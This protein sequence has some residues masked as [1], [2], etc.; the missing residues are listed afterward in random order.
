MP[1]YSPFSGGPAAT[2]LSGIFAQWDTGAVARGLASASEKVGNAITERYMQT[3]KDKTSAGHLDALLGSEIADHVLGVTGQTKD[4]VKTLNDSQKA[5]LLGQYISTSTLLKAKDEHD[6]RE[7]DKQIK[8]RT[9]NSSKMLPSGMSSLLGAKDVDELS[10]NFSTFLNSGGDDK[11]SGMTSADLSQL[12]KVY[13][14]QLSGFHRSEAPKEVF[15]GEFVMK[16]NSLYPN[17]ARNRNSFTSTLG[18]LFNDQTVLH[19]QRKEIEDNPGA[20]PSLVDADKALANIDKNIAST[21]LAIKK[22]STPT[23][24]MSFEFEDGKWRID[25]GGG[26]SDATIGTKSEMQKKVALLRATSKQLQHA[27]SLYKDEYVGMSGYFGQKVGDE[28]MGSLPFGWG[29]KATDPG[30]IEFR[31]SMNEFNISVEKTLSAESRFSDKDRAYIRTALANLGATTSPA[32]SRSRMVSLGKLLAMRAVALTEE[33]GGDLSKLG[34]VP[35]STALELFKGGRLEREKL[36]TILESKYKG[37]SAVVDADP[38]E[39]DEIMKRY[40]NKIPD[41]ELIEL[42][43]ELFPKGD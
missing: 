29:E 41:I 3:K 19:K 24:P 43:E 38:S 18:K 28:F 2:D 9:V 42:L 30:R 10:N 20:Y 16:G 39:A 11:F 21:E 33:G 34:W 12:E 40:S 15:N 23:K 27:R 4:S 6:S 32:Q 35:S 37:L 14:T 1:R 31:D 36:D 22:M 5:G 8:Q 26:T 17:P 25:M 7:L 13:T